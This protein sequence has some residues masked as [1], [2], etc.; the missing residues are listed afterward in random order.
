MFFATPAS[1]GPSSRASRSSWGRSPASSLR[2]SWE[3]RVAPRRQLFLRAR[4]GVCLAHKSHAIL[5]AGHWVEGHFERKRR[6][7]HVAKIPRARRMLM[8]SGAWCLAMPGCASVR[9]Q[10][11]WRQ[12]SPATTARFS[13][14][15][16][17][18]CKNL[19]FKW[20]AACCLL[21]EH[22]LFVLR[23]TEPIVIRLST[24]NLGVPNR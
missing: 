21:R 1:F 3:G 22:G 10:L 23:S 4:H 12:V 7:N 6:A 13:C 8:S 5:W 20:L 2:P 15:R 19:V 14:C 9:A 24:T 17:S 11:R 18:P 16:L